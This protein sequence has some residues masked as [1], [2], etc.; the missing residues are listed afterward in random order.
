MEQVNK[1]KKYVG[2]S[3]AT[4]GVDPSVLGSGGAK[5]AGD[6]LKSR[7]QRLEEEMRKAG[8]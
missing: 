1:D 4:G 6:A 5:K 7:Q 8:A 2:S 3:P